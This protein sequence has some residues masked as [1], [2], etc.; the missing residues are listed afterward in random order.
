MKSFWVAFGILLTQ[1]ACLCG[2]SQ[3]VPCQLNNPDQDTLRLFPERTNYRT[4]F[5]RTDEVGKIRQRG[6]QALYRELEMRLGDFWDP[7]WE[8]EDIPYVFYEILKGPE[9]IGWVFGANQGWPGADN[10]QL[11]V[12][13][14]LEERIREFYY[15]KLPSME[16]AALQNKQFYAQFLGL[17]LQQ[18]Y[19]HERLNTLNIQKKEMQPLD[20]IQRIQDPT[21]REQE[22]FQKTLRGLKK[23]LIYLDEFKFHNAIKKDEVFKQV[24]S[25]VTKKEKIPLLSETDPLKRIKKAFPEASRFVIDLVSVEQNK[26]VLEERLESSFG[27][28]GIYPVYVVYKENVYKEPFVRGE[29]LGYVVPLSMGDMTAV[30]AIGAEGKEKGKIVFLSVDQVDFPEFK[31]LSLVHFYTKDFLSRHR[32]EDAQLDRIAPLVNLKVHDKDVSEEMRKRAKKALVLIDDHYFHTYF[33]KEEI[34]RKIEE[35]KKGSV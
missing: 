11:M 16:N 30:V 10:A 4:E 8:T 20:M 22:G 23:I 5:L 21:E 24:D 33:K 15:Q 13:V 18:F 7:I 26:G 2:Q 1:L 25:F 9:R 34:M 28:E 29:L 14:D 6:P 31:G 17:S 32:M 35:Y 3:V 27:E 12:A 19:I